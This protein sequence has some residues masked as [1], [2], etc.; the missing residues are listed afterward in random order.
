MEYNIIPSK[1]ECVDCIM[2]PI[3]HR[4]CIY[5]QH[6]IN[7]Y[8]L[9]LLFN[10]QKNP[11]PL[12]DSYSTLVKSKPTLKLSSAWLA[13]FWFI[14]F[15]IVSNQKSDVTYP[16]HLFRWLPYIFFRQFLFF[17]FLPFLLPSSGHQS[18]TNSKW[19]QLLCFTHQS[20]TFI[21]LDFFLF[22]SFFFFQT[23]FDHIIHVCLC[24]CVFCSQLKGIIPAHFHTL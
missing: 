17:L 7:Q 1:Y 4:K 6:S 5:Y 18:G 2:L 11:T 13:C 21:Y 9:W 23:L 24:V 19:V 22:I 12:P 15:F 3:H 16:L 8:L 10:K 14:I 20:L